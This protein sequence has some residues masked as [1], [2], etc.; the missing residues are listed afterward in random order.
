[1]NKL[2]LQRFTFFIQ[3]LPENSIHK[4]LFNIL[5]LLRKLFPIPKY[6]IS[7]T[8]RKMYETHILQLWPFGNNG[9]AFAVVTC[10]HYNM[11]VLF[12]YSGVLNN[13]DLGLTIWILI[14]LV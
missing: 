8:I 11:K 7:H 4:Q 9:W 12:I 6:K 5:Y 3:Q 14:I 10:L 13:K 1:M 2:K